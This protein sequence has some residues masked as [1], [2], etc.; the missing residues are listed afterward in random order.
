[1]GEHSPQE[2]GLQRS[3]K[4]EVSENWKSLAG[5]GHAL[6][7]LQNDCYCCP[8]SLPVTATMPGR[9]CCQLQQPVWSKAFQG[10]G[11][12]DQ[13]CRRGEPEARVKLQDAK[14]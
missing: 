12:R 13:P 1:M 9:G 5:K 7:A 8:R 10:H 2:M 11:C 3:A 14:G 6:K 4:V